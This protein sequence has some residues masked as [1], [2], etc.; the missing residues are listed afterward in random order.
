MLWNRRLGHISKQRIESLVSDG[1]LGPLDL[2]DFTVCIECIK[3]KQT[4]VR[5]LSA[6]RSSSV[7]ELIHTDICGPFLTAS[8]NGQQYF[9][10]FI[11]DYSRYGYIYLIYEKSQSL[12]VFKAYKAEVE[13]QLD[14]KIKAVKSDRGGEYYG[15]YDGS[16]E[17]RPGPFAKY[18]VECG[19]VP[20]YTMPG[21]PSMNGV[22]ERRNRTL[23]DMVRSMISHSTL[24]ESL[25]G[26]ALKTAAYILNS[27]EQSSS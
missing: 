12:D 5:K 24:P 10:T 14:K 15:R 1:I 4:N 26:D 8:W 27:T 23:K 21:K 18:L 13:N 11:D 9:I 19:I 17:Q 2:A 6:N 22:A 25:W 7:L 3:G 16:G 20:Q